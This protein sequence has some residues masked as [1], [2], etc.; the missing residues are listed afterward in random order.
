M[1]NNLQ[2]INYTMTLGRALENIN[3][4]IADSKQHEELTEEEISLMEVIH[5]KLFLPGV[6]SFDKENI[7]ADRM[8]VRKVR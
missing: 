3:I 8:R 2:F 7:N 5:K 6:V 4:K 1:K